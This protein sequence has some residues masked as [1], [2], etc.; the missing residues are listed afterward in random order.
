M[1]IFLIIALLFC[2]CVNSSVS[3]VYGQ[4]DGKRLNNTSESYPF[5]EEEYILLVS[6]Y[7]FRNPWAFKIQETIKRSL[8]VPKKLGVYVVTLPCSPHFS[9]DDCRE[10]FSY[11]FNRYNKKPKTIVF[12]GEQGWEL[13]RETV[14]E[15]WKDVP[16]VLSMFQDTIYSFKNYKESGSSQIGESATVEETC[17]GFN[18]TLVHADMSTERTI[19]LMTNV[20]PDL[21]QIV[22]ITDFSYKGVIFRNKLEQSFQNMSD[23]ELTFLDKR[24]MSTEQLLDTIQ[25]LDRHSA[26][27]FHSWQLIPGEN[28]YQADNYILYKYIASL[29]SVPAF[30]TTDLMT[31]HDLFLGGA[32]VA[33]DEIGLAVGQAVK[34]AMD[35]MDAMDAR[36]DSLNSIDITST[37]KAFV[38][39][40][41]LGRYGL[42]SEIKAGSN[43]VVFINKSVTFFEANRVWIEVLLVSFVF[44]LIV[45]FFFML[46]YLKGRRMQQREFELIKKLARLNDTMPILHTHIKLLY[47]EQGRYITYD[48][49]YSNTALKDHIRKYTGEDIE[50]SRLKELVRPTAKDRLVME[51]V[52]KNKQTVISTWYW[53]LTKRHYQI[54]I[55]PAENED[56]VYVFYTDITELIDA[57]HTISQFKNKVMELYMNLPVAVVLLNE[58]LK[59]IDCN[60]AFCE[61][62]DIENNIFIYANADDEL[63]KLLTYDELLS[64]GDK[65]FVSKEITIERE[66]DN[67]NAVARTFWC[68][69]EAVEADDD[70][71]IKCYALL[72][73]NHVEINRSIEE[74]DRFS[75]VTNRTLAEIL[76]KMPT[77]VSI[78]DAD[79]DF[80]YVYWNRKS[81][82]L[83]N[84]PVEQVIGS[85]DYDFNP[86]KA[87][88][89][90]EED[91]ALISGKTSL[92]KREDVIDGKVYSTRKSMIS[93]KDSHRWI[94]I[95]MWNITDKRE[96]EQ[97]L[98][99]AKDTMEHALNT[100]K[101]ILDNIDVGVVYMD[102]EYNVLLSSMHKFNTLFTGKI[103]KEGTVCYKHMHKRK[104]PCT[105]CPIKEMFKLKRNVTVETVIENR[106]LMIAAIPVM[107]K[108]G[109]I[110]GGIM[111]I[112]DVS[113]QR[114]F[115]HQLQESAI[116]LSMALEL[117]NIIPCSWNLETDE[118][119]FYTSASDTTI[120]DMAR[121]AEISQDEFRKTIMIQDLEAY[122]NSLLAIKRNAMSDF[123]VTIRSNYFTSEYR[124]YQ[125]Q[126]V[127]NE[128]NKK[129]K[130]VRGI[131]FIQDIT[132]G[133]KAEEE[134]IVAKE[135]A[136][137]ANRL[138]S[139]FLANMSHEIRTPLNAIVGFSEV[140]VD[141]ETEEERQMCAQHIAV[142]ND[143]LLQLISDILD[144]SKIESE[145]LDFVYSEVDI[146]QLFDGIYA[147]SYRRMQNSDVELIMEKGMKQCTVL[148]EKIRFM[149]VITN[150]INNAIKFTQRGHIK[151]GYK[152]MADENML[153]FYVEDTGCGIPKQK[154]TSVFERFVKLNEFVQGTGLGLA[155]CKTI[156]ERLGGGIYVESVEGQGS[157]FSFTIPYQKV[158]IVP[159]VEDVSE[160]E[161][162]NIEGGA[163]QKLILIAEDTMSNFILFETILKENYR[164]I[165]AV[166]GV[167]AVDLFYKHKPDLV[168]MDI[169]MPKMDGIEATQIIRRSDMQTPIIAVTAHAFMENDEVMRKSG[170]TAF[171]SKPIK[172]KSFLSVLN[173]IM[174]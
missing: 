69:A 105:R 118:I 50:E 24:N 119:N 14:P 134:L 110:T 151:I 149:Q 61:M 84:M 28:Y 10:R 138:K 11:I 18:A 58:E 81:V 123:K 15:S 142:N 60:K 90:R 55:Y 64:V 174:S 89:F 121:Y 171:V 157:T 145:T 150:L 79:D 166:D 99:V 170:F 154:V 27:L 167:E 30:V 87:D 165:H 127:V 161:L 147:Q 148:T 129:G 71:N 160:T 128:K 37:I 36:Y 83:W 29:L 116:R 120:S 26:V 3:Y 23:L 33:A 39:Y 32:F 45:V 31:Y 16:V 7:H 51:S 163:S 67:G 62:V 155:I 44:L 56:E 53:A 92:I 111:R 46:S 54:Y 2:T 168:L 104:I 132:Q 140:L 74:G 6:Y 130:N 52:V 19:E 88:A 86:G 101:T 137:E 108:H 34:D 126:G 42:G 164:L 96:A 77:G 21:K 141:A 122:D 169:K 143:V 25:K 78:K 22:A 91:L 109:G 135:H 159:I 114:S 133:K 65:T 57:Q 156:V 43:D 136:E 38:D 41:V 95:F 146:N 5:A 80:R 117:G 13:Y 162:V 66:D 12:I 131:G 139:A 113:Q 85:T 112:I 48:T 93:G 144:L 70:L 94:I 1:K 124:W 75:L 72:F 100:C 152:L 172:K 17:K 35:A 9:Y 98:M 8:F 40:N 49:I 82:E 158:N 125:I 47:D 107:D 115:E 73:I 97:Q 106:N 20:V 59:T 102:T 68:M 173:D 153:L 103:Y 63:A 76:D 4:S